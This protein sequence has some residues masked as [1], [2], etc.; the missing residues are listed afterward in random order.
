ML[1]CMSFTSEIK[2]MLFRSKKWVRRKQDIGLCR[3]LWGMKLNSGASVLASG[4][5]SGGRHSF[6]VLRFVSGSTVKSLPVCS[7]DGGGGIML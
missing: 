4:V 2:Q 6:G 5:S 7:S 3:C 1:Q